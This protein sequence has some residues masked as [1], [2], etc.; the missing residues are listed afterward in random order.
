MSDT[1]KWTP[2]PWRVV[3]P[4]ES[5]EDYFG[6]CQVKESL[7]W[8][9]ICEQVEQQAN[10]HLIAAAPDLYHAL[11]SLNLMCV[12]GYGIC[13]QLG[14]DDPVPLKWKSCPVCDPARA[15]LKKAR[16]EA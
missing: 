14:A 6:V 15:A 2:G 3:P 9:Y 7:G 13:E 11:N 5:Y 16:G 4:E 8:V 10:A 1:P 12:C